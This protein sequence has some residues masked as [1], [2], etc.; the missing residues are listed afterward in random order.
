MS[1][2][3]GNGFVNLLFNKIFDLVESILSHGLKPKD[4]RWLSV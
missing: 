1:F 3:S 4:E 2:Q